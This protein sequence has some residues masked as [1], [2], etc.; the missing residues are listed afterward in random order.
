MDFDKYIFKNSDG[1][2]DTGYQKCYG[3]NTQFCYKTAAGTEDANCPIVHL[4]E[5]A[6]ANGIFSSTKDIDTVAVAADKKA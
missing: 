5:K 1:N 3:V 4:K 6:S 2:C